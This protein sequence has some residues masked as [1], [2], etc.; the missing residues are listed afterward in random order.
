MYTFKAEG[1]HAV[2]LGDETVAGIGY[3]T[4]TPR[5]NDGRAVDTVATMNT[6]GKIRTSGEGGIGDDTLKL[7]QWAADQNDATAYQV[8]TGTAIA[9]GQNLRTYTLANAFVINYKESFN[10]NSGVGTYDLVIRQKKD[11]L[12][13]VSITGGYGLE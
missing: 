8:A 11:L 2:T 1:A 9:G 13:G 7:A 4:E 6:S 5:H 10:V 12:E 3:R